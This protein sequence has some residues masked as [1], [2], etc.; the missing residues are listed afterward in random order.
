[1]MDDNPAGL[2]QT[3][4]GKPVDALNKSAMDHPAMKVSTMTSVTALHGTY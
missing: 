1:M 2:V 3:E 4:L